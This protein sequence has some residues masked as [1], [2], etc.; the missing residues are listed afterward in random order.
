MN[1]VLE[2]AEPAI[3][4][5]KDIL[6]DSNT[7]SSLSSSEVEVGEENPWYPQMGIH[8]SGSLNTSPAP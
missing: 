4:I 7:Q 5:L 2:E 8:L 3:R 6:V 1:S